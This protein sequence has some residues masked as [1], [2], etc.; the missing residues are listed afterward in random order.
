MYFDQVKPNDKGGPTYPGLRLAFESD[1]ETLHTNCEHNLRES[2]MSMW[3]NTIQH[4]ITR[5]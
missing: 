3:Y 1:Q 5:K 2:S 4:H